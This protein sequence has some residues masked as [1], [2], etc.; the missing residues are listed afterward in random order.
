MQTGAV[1]EYIDIAQI[2]LYVFWLF[3]AGLVYYLHRENKREG[4]PLVDEKTG[5][6]NVHGWPR[7]PTERKGFVQYDGSV[8][9]AP[10]HERVDPANGTPIAPWPGA[11]LQPNG[12]PLLSEMGP[13]AYANRADVPDHCFD[14]HGPKIIPLRALPDFFL[15]NEDPNVIGMTV[16][17][18]DGVKAGV[19]VDAWADRSEVVVRYLEV[20]LDAAIGTGRVLIPMNFVTIKKRLGQIHTNTVLGRQFATVPRTRNPET[21]T[22][23]EEEKVMAYYGGGLLYA[24]PDRAEPVL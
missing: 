6:A 10:R 14:D 3:F 9:L 16:H 24:T 17:G 4:Y 7:V 13:G 5:A 22:M 15:A 18:L 23:L 19:V 20:E 1:T 12:D 2:T 21:I 11:A 8:I